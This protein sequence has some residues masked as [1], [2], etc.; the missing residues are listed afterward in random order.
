MLP[1]FV[2]F[3]V[4]PSTPWSMCLPQSFFFSKNT[5]LDC[6]NMYLV[7]LVNIWRTLWSSGLGEPGSRGWG[8]RL[9]GVGGTA[10]PCHTKAFL[11]RESKNPFRQAWLGNNK[12]QV[13]ILAKVLY[14]KELPKKSDFGK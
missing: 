13:D 2:D 12:V 7:D 10:G 8:N 14:F 3:R 9:A 11:I 4:P 6:W 5:P 1:I